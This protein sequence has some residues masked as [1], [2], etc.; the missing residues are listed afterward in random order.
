MWPAAS[1]LAGGDIREAPTGGAEMMVVSVQTV[2][3]ML[4]AVCCRCEPGC[5]VVVGDFSLAGLSDLVRVGVVVVG[6]FSVPETWATDGAG[7]GRRC[8][9]GAHARTVRPHPAR[10]SANYLDRTSPSPTART[11]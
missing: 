2:P 8:R 3:P 9:A 7:G 1:P 11:S 10:P 5:V 4:L 6:D